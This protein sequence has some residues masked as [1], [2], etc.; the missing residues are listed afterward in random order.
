MAHDPVASGY[1]YGGSTPYHI[2]NPGGDPFADVTPYEGNYAGGD[3]YD[4]VP[5]YQGSVNEQDEH[6]IQ[7]SQ[8]Q[9]HASTQENLAVKRE[10][11]LHE[12]CKR[13]SR[14]VKR[15]ICKNRIRCFVLLF[16]IAIFAV[17]IVLV[18]KMKEDFDSS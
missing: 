2:N 8:T 5:Q 11:K 4:D 13:L 6:F 15:C 16:S 10:S 3:T 18:I 7:K 12:Q 17:F 9:T 14:R 1:P